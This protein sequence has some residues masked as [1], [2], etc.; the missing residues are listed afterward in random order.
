M[1]IAVI[2]DIHGNYE[3]LKSVI[4]DIQTQKID[5]IFCLGDTIGKGVHLRECLDLVRK[6]CDVV[7]MGNVDYRYSGNPEEFAR[8]K[9]E[10]ELIKYNRSIMTAEDIEFVQNLPYCYEMWLSGNLVRFFHVGPSSLFSLT[11]NYDTDLQK[12]LDLFRPGDYTLSKDIADVV[13]YGHI[14][15]Q[16]LE[17]VFN[18]TLVNCGSVG[19][20][21]CVMYDEKYNSEPREIVQAHYLIIEGDENSKTT[22][23]LGFTFRSVNYDSASELENGKYNPEY[24]I[25]EK[26][27]L[28]G[29]Y[30]NIDRAIQRMKDQGW[31][32]WLFKK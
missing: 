25:Y 18:R 1:R 31:K 32:W 15:Y 17:K 3:A 21:S 26:E 16:F 10:Y 13:V 6:H 14:H 30:R 27:I 11:Y 28:T 29:K 4:E 2:S 20:S 5:K 22:Q 9:E 7:L 8:D 24:E 12:Q 19:G 23:N